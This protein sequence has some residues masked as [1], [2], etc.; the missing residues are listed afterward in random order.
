MKALSEKEIAAVSRLAGP[1]RYRHAVKR[2]V[3]W[4]VAWGLWRDGWAIMETDEGAQQVLPFWPATEYAERHR[5]G[6]WI[7]YEPRAIPLTELLD[8]LLPRMIE[9]GIKPGVF[10][11]PGGRGVVVSVS[12]FDAALREAL[13]CYQFNDE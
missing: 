4:E 13:L 6:S 2:I 1:A 3:D 7:A 12:E 11:L 10:P 9:L 8:E 5:E